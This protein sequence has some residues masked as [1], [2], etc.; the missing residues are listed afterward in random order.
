MEQTLVTVLMPVFNG[1]LYLREA[2]DSILN[3]TYKNLEL[4]IINDGSNDRSIEIINTYKDQRIRLINFEK[5]Q[6]LITVL[7]VGI[8]EAKGCYIARMDA[9]D[10][11]YPERIEKQLEIFKTHPELTICSTLMSINR[12]SSVYFKSVLNSDEIKA[13]LLFDNLVCHPTVMY[14]SSPFIDSCY[15]YKMDFPHAEDYALWLDFIE[16]ETFNII[17]KTL[18]KYREHDTQV[19]KKNRLSQ[20]NS[21]VKAQSILLNKLGVNP[22]KEELLIHSKIFFIDYHY[23]LSFFIEAEKWLLKLKKQNQKTNIFSP[24]DFEN[25]LSWS[26]FEICTDFASKKY[27]CE[28][29]FKNSELYNFRVYSKYYLI[30][31]E[32]KNLIAY[33]TL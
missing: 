16:K 2:I 32:L 1:E 23:N 18:L 20:I 3:Q 11:A 28:K 21:V 25:I 12:K 8:N 14:K 19:S 9:D 17:P 13:R 30:K 6:G 5:N 22:T 29:L 4:L 27:R 24:V 15:Y 31:F 33:K 10:V 26:W 7:N